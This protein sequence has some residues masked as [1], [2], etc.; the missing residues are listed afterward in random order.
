MA[1]V[2]NEPYKEVPAVPS[3]GYL[4]GI[5]RGCS[6]MVSTQAPSLPLPEI[7]SS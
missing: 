6:K 2:M 7:P 3:P 5:L 1:Y 4:N